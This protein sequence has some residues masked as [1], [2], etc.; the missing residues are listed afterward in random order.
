MK[1]RGGV[2]LRS[3]T[4]GILD[5]VGILFVIM[6]LTGTL[7]SLVIVKIPRLAA[8]AG[9]QLRAATSHLN[10]DLI[11]PV[12]AVASAPPPTATLVYRNR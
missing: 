2:R 10:L 12:Q 5:V 3:P 6:L 1:Q 4:I 7:T 11:L 8:H 9:E